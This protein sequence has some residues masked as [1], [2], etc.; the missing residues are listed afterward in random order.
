MRSRKL[1]CLYNSTAF[2]MFRVIFGIHLG[3]LEHE[4]RWQG[5][6]GHGSLAKQSA[7]HMQHGAVCL[8]HPKQVSGSR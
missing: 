1:F 6:S 3:D 5:V 2:F 7:V 8:D 4:G